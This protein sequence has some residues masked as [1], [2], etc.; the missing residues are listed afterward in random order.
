MDEIFIKLF[1]RAYIHM[2]KKASKDSLPEMKSGQNK[3][4]GNLF[5]G[6]FNDE[7]KAEILDILSKNKYIPQEILSSRDF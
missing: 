4:I 7:Y 6:E 1:V 2:L 3:N 5:L